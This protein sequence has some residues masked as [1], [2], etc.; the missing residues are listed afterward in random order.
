MLMVMMAI[1][2][3]RMTMIIQCNSIEFIIIYMLSQQPQGQLQT[4][5]S[6]DNVVTYWTNTT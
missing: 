2:I 3:M 1:M 5:Y 4:Q 6:V